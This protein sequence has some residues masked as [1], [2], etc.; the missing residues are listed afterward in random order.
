MSFAAPGWLAALALVPIAIAAS[1]A[2]RRR[3]RRY[4]VRFPAVSTLAL[5]DAGGAW[6]RRLPAAFALAAIAALALALARPHVSYSASAREASVMLVSDESGSMASTDVQ[7]SRLAAAERAA[8]SFIASLPSGARVGAIAFSSAVNA[9]QAP[10][11]D[12]AGARSV[13]DSQVAD[14]ATAT[15]NALALALSLLDGSNPKHAPAAI[16]LLSDGA[17]NAGLDVLSVAGD[18]ARE[19]IPIY[20]VALGT[21]DG[22][23]AN[24]DPF[25]PAIAVPPDPQLMAAIAQTSRGRTFDAQ[26]A[27]QL[28]AIYK[29][30]GSQLGTV[31]RKR[32]VTAEFALGALV[33]LA[34]ALLSSTRWSPRL[35]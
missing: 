3:A 4:A 33:L 11:S 6:R 23:L 16:V 18:A 17:A 25:A 34:L 27:G 2:A 14:G 13:I 32:E 31:T 5:L 1:I 21:A 9:V 12:H 35:P 24:P 8:N 20:T 22:T 30:L 28:S 15:G 29:H 10:S 26:S 19:R 7:P